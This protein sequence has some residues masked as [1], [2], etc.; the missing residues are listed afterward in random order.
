MAHTRTYARITLVISEPRPFLYINSNV[1]GP[2]NTRS[3]DNIVSNA[4]ASTSGNLASFSGV[5]GKAVQ[6][7]ALVAANVVTNAGNAISGRVAT[8]SANKV[9][10][11]G[12]A[13]QVF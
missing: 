2:T 13:L 5:T 9:I 7:T 1:A 11:D 3:V 4:G 8:F 10:Q 6:D 12:G